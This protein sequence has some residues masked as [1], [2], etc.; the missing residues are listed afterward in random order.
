MHDIEIRDWLSIESKPLKVSD[1]DQAQSEPP[2]PIPYNYVESDHHHVFSIEYRFYDILLKIKKS[3]TLF[4][5]L[6]NFSDI[7]NIRFNRAEPT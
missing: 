7:Q 6:L 3:L 4:I 1:H 5:L 2:R